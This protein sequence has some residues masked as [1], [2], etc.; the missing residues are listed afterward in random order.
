MSQRA[1]EI[2]VNSQLERCSLPDLLT[3]EGVKEPLVKHLVEKLMPIFDRAITYVASI[4][5][6]VDDDEEFETLIEFSNETY[7][8]LVGTIYNE[9]VTYIDSLYGDFKEAVDFVVKP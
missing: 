5:E 4:D 2:F 7:D 1:T 9:D 3:I 8:I 6:D